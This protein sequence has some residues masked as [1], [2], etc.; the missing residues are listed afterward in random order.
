MESCRRSPARNQHL[1]LPGGAAGAMDTLLRAISGARV[2]AVSRLV[3]L[4]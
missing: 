2:S 1:G 4:L 3:F